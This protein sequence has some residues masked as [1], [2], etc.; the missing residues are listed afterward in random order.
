MKKNK[1]ISNSF[2]ESFKLIKKN[3]IIFLVLFLLQLLFFSLV[4][5]VN[6]YYQ[7]KILG[8]VGNVMDYLSKQ[9]PE[10]ENILG[11]DPLM[12]HR[13]YK[14]IIYNLRLL[15]V[16]CFLIFVLINGS[17]FYLINKLVYNKKFNFKQRNSTN[18][19]IGGMSSARKPPTKLAEFRASKTTKCKDNK[20]MPPVCD[21]W[22]LT[23]CF[24][25]YQENAKELF[26]CLFKFGIACLVFFLLIFLFAYPSFKGSILV[27]TFLFA[28]PFDPSILNSVS[29]ISFNLA[30]LLIIFILFYFMYLTFSLIYKIELRNIF[31]KLFNVGVKKAYIILLTYF[32]NL[33]VIHALFLLIVFL[34]EWNIILLSLIVLLFILSFVWTKIF[35]VNVVKKLV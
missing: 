31:K 12:I 9:N 20:I 28:Y 15:A 34:I 13:N 32:I 27:L 25:R 7:P 23:N 33:I 10:D 22:F 3:K 19:Q 6:F 35:L 11:E 2:K 26:I 1:I 8:S 17:M 29:E 4:F 21:W 30:S 5:I 18:H 24:K 16:W 14:D